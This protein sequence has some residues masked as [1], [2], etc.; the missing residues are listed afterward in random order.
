[1][2]SDINRLYSKLLFQCVFCNNSIQFNLFTCKL[3]SPE[4]NYKAIMSREEKNT[5]KQNTKTME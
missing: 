1:M 3:N 2:A 5:Y 4:A